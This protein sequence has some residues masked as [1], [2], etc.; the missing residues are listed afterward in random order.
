MTIVRDSHNIGN[1]TG[2][3]AAIDKNWKISL[4][5]NGGSETKNMNQ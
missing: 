2:F 5:R 4:L 3:K 1:V